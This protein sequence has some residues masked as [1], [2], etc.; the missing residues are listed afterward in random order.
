AE[1]GRQKGRAGVTLALFVPEASLLRVVEML[2]VPQ[3]S[4]GEAHALRF[5]R[6]PSLKTRDASRSLKQLQKREGPSVLTDMV[7]EDASLA[8]ATLPDNLDKLQHYDPPEP[9]QH[10]HPE[11]GSMGRGGGEGGR[12]Q[13]E[14]QHQQ[15]T[16]VKRPSITTRHVQRMSGSTASREVTGQHLQLQ[17][18]SDDGHGA[19]VNP[20]G[21]G[22]GWSRGAGSGPL[23]S[24]FAAMTPANSGSGHFRGGP[25]SVG[26]TGSSRAAGGEPSG[27]VPSSPPPPPLRQRGRGA[28]GVG[29]VSG[30]GRLSP[31]EEEPGDE[32]ERW[33][34]RPQFPLAAR[35]DP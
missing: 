11:E 3:P 7:P 1:L 33:K 29:Q 13:Q 18:S 17:G 27:G 26:A 34:W 19:G 15:H 5:S 30:G 12:G 32:E 31:A 25:G 2:G 35:R 20:G 23:L 24:P 9:P 28:R 16:V 22:Q 10:P 6:K 4:F 8:T 14:Q 21:Q